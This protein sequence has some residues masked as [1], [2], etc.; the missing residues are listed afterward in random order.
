MNSMGLEGYSCAA[1]MP[2]AHSRPAA[3]RQASA[4]R[5]P[6]L[7]ILHVP[8]C[9]CLEPMPLPHTDGPCPALTWTQTDGNDRPH[10][11]DQ[12]RGTPRYWTRQCGTLRV[13]LAHVVRDWV[14][15]HTGA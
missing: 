8:Q 10:S 5:R 3:T 11:H 15:R 4:R 12:H 14:S 1:G 13:L 9:P 2:G 7:D 6:Q